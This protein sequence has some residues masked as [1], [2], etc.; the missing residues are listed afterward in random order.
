M[1]AFICSNPSNGLR[2]KKAIP[3]HW[4]IPAMS[5]NTEII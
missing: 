4:A 3:H 5:M 2:S 1:S